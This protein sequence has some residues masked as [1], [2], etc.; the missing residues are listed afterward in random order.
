RVLRAGMAADVQVQRAVAVEVD[1]REP[2]EPDLGEVAPVA[3]HALLDPRLLREVAE[4]LLGRPRRGQQREQRDSDELAHGAASYL[5]GAGFPA[6]TAP[7]SVPSPSA[8]SP[9]SM[10]G[11]SGPGE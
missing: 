10:S 2:R 5:S 8:G 7:M 6:S 4:R 11:L 9:A 1:Q 3:R